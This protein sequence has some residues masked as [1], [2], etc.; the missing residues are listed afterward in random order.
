MLDGRA[1]DWPGDADLHATEVGGRLHGAFGV[2]VI[3]FRREQAD[4]LKDIPPLQQA[5]FE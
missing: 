2:E 3:G 5:S 1:I 4:D